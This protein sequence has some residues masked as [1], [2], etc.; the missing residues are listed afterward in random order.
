L[1]GKH[2]I[3]LAMAPNKQDPVLRKKM[4]SEVAQFLDK[5]KQED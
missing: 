1:K 4:E 3:E 2:A 5:A